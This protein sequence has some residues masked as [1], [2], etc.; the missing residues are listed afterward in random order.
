MAKEQFKFLPRHID[1]KVKRKNLIAYLES[2]DIDKKDDRI[3]NFE[4]F[5]LF[6]NLYNSCT[7]I[8]RNEDALSDRNIKSRVHTIVSSSTTSSDLAY[9]ADNIDGVIGSMREQIAKFGNEDDFEKLGETAKAWEKASEDAKTHIAK[10]KE[11]VDTNLKNGFG[12]RFQLKRLERQEFE[13]K[14]DEV[15]KLLNAGKTPSEIGIELSL[16]TGYIMNFESELVESRLNTNIE[17]IKT[18]MV[19]NVSRLDIADELNVTKNRLS[20]F[21]SD[22]Q[23]VDA[24]KKKI[25]AAKK[26]EKDTK[27]KKAKVEPKTEAKKEPVKKTTEAVKAEPKKETAKKPTEK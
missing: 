7:E 26:A 15:E 19:E 12:T 18:K 6:S 27:P 2:M 5:F 3:N 21:I 13:E 9:I 11:I 10:L 17:L 20:K 8:M 4:D 1:N 23:L 24:V 25:E 16:K 22:K 14:K